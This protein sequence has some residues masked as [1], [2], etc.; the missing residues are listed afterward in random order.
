M[1]DKKG[2][3]ITYNWLKKL[4]QVIY[5][6][7]R[8]EMLGDPNQVPLKSVQLKCGTTGKIVNTVKFHLK[9]L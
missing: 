1:W 5:E 4:K 2:E 6:D 9:N 3:N 8:E 7:K